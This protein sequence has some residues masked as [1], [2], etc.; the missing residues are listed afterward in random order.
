M[1]NSV[2]NHGATAQKVVLDRLRKQLDDQGT[3]TVLR[4]GIELL[5]LRQPLQL[6]QFKPALAMNP[7]HKMNISPIACRRAPSTL[8][9]A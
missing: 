2:K 5:G 8:F 3:T 6:A 9:T 1:A 4:H 7:R